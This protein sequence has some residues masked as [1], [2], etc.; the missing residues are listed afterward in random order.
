MVA[1][2]RR[3][4][5]PRASRIATR[6][7]D[8]GARA[9][10]RA[11]GSSERNINRLER[12]NTTLREEAEET[13][14]AQA[15]IFQAISHDLRNPLGVILMSAQLM[16]AKTAADQPNRRQI[17]AISRAAGELNHMLNDVS[18]I[19]KL[20][21]RRLILRRLT[22]DAGAMIDQ[23]LGEIRPLAESKSIRISRE[24]DGD[25]LVFVGD[26]DRLIKILADLVGN[27]VKVTPKQGLITI[28][29]A[30]H[31][32]GARFAVTDTG[33]GISPDQRP[34]LFTIPT[35]P[36]RTMVQGTGLAAY[37]AKG[38]I[39]AHGGRIWAESEVGRGT[40]F[41]FT[42]PASDGPVEDEPPLN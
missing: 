20:I 28:R 31:D 17:D 6:T 2:P 26:R 29:A 10:S 15:A 16:A 27:A 33:T 14:I 30:P 18:D 13:E 8:G 1:L 41:F 39:E 38:I 22:C 40:T 23:V 12:L 11:R 19:G 9:P 37:V 3:T 42:V 4:Q 35:G 24:I 7:A 25:V 32:G 5:A 21:A 34:L 36:R